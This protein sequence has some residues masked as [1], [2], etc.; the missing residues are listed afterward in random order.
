MSATRVDRE[1]MVRPETEGGE[2][3]TPS[4]R[5]RPTEE[6]PEK[7]DN[8]TAAMRDLLMTRMREARDSGTLA[9]ILHRAACGTRGE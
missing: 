4:P 9:E 7:C 6:S 5:V 2:E 1:H 8:E 3:T